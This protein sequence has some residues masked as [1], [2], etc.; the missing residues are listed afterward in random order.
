MVI[1]AREAYAI[2]KEVDPT[3]KVVSP[4]VTAAVGISWLDQ[5]FNNGGASFADIIGY[6]F[7]VFPNPPEAMVPIIN[8]VRQT[9]TKYG[10][11]NKPIWNTEAG[12]AKPKLFSSDAE[13]SDYVARSYILNWAAGI[14][15][16]YWYA[17]DNHGWVTL[18][19]T[20]PDNITLKPAAIAYREVQKWIVGSKV[21][22][23]AQDNQGTWLTKIT[24]SN[25]YKGFIVWNPNKTI[26]FAI[27]KEWNV[28]NMKDLKG[29]TTDITGTSQLSVDMGPV[30]LENG[31]NSPAPNS[32]KNI[33]VTY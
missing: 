1:L 4:P 27:P 12:W 6:H 10:I 14:D 2:L 29:S 8:D 24:R 7:Y 19:M 13:A 28:K 9:M 15:R 26:D 33:L 16:F 5:Y 17:W 11:S 30:F 32:P 3:I 23:C 18:E 21:L 22:S 20:Q 31:L 25:G